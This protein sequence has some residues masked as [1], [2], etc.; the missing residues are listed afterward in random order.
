MNQIIQ[1]R[2]QQTGK[3]EWYDGSKCIAR[4]GNHNYLHHHMHYRNEARFAEYKEYQIVVEDGFSVIAPINVRNSNAQEI[5]HN[6]EE[7]SAIRPE[8]FIGPMPFNFRP[9]SSNVAHWDVMHRQRLMQRTVSLVAGGKSN[10]AIVAGRGG[11]GKTYGV[12]EVVDRLGLVNYAENVAKAN[13]IA[14]E[15]LQYKKE[16]NIEIEDDDDDTVLEMKV[17]QQCLLNGNQYAVMK[18]YSSTSALYKFLWEHNNMLIIFDDCD[19]ILKDANAANL[20][21]AALDTYEERWISWNVNSMDPNAPPSIFKFTGRVIFITNMEMHN[22]NEAVRTR[23]YKVDMTMSKQQCV[24]YI[25]NTANNVKLPGIESIQQD[26]LNDALQFL[27]VYADKI[28]T[29][30]YRLFLDVL[31]VRIECND[32]ASWAELAYFNIMQN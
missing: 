2:N 25:K 17:R 19:S 23:C 13:E 8:D 5:Q 22:I 4:S 18:G 6:V 7:H 10:G 28:H 26:E 30:S 12:M 24:E 31:R 16:N 29:I 15:I 20:L 3:F 1:K 14:E 27:T 9:I 21:K 32:D 11:I